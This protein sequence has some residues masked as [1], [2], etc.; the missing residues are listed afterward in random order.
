MG[1][2][3]GRQN[4]RAVFY[5]QVLMNGLNI[6]LDLYFVLVLDWGVAGVAGGAKQGP[7]GMPPAACRAG[8]SKMP[9]R[10]PPL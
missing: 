1:W 9:G 3:I 6:V 7:R 2:F 5:V 8:A 4:T 10:R